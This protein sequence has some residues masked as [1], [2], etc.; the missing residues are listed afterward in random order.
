MEE[1][2]AELA[3]LFLA[4]NAVTLPAT[5]EALHIG[6]DWTWT[7]PGGTVSRIDF[8]GIPLEWTEAVTS[9]RVIDDI[10]MWPPSQD[11]LVPVVAIS[12]MATGR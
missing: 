2:V 1:Q 11:H 6:Q 4:D 3:H 8:V 5:S 12:M 7:R 9:S 10:D